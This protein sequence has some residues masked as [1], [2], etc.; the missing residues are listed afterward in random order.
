MAEF[1]TAYSHDESFTSYSEQTE[2]DE[3]NSRTNTLI[4]VFRRSRQKERQMSAA[5]LINGY[6]VLQK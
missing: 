4:L 3:H 2:G 6:C 1:Q 5:F